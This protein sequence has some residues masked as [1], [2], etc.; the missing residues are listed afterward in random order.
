MWKL[1]PKVVGSR[2]RGELRVYKRKQ[3]EGT[4]PTVPLVSTSPSSRSTS[5]PE[6]P[7]PSTTDSEYTNDMIP[8][9][10][11][12][13]P[14]T[15]RRTSRSNAEH[16][17]QRCGSHITL[18]SIFDTLTHHLY[19]KHSLHL[20]TLSIYLSVGRKVRIQSEKQQCRK[21]LGLSIKTKY[22]R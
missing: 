18:P 15:L 8:P 12:P 14:M 9:S 17:T 10:S 2:L 5:T 7:I 20:W 21:N 11:S 3:N 6:T 16:P 4:L 13:T 1:S 19:I 22:G